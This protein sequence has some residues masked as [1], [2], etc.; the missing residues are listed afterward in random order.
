MLDF[1]KYETKVKSFDQV[2]EEGDRFVEQKIASC[3]TE[4][5][6]CYI[7]YNLKYIAME[8]KI[9]LKYDAL[10]YKVIDL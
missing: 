8:F 10:K 4:K 5:L 2:E 9:N 6:S 3:K 7:I 1:R